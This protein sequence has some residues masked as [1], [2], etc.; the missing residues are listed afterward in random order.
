MNQNNGGKT[1]RDQRGDKTGATAHQVMFQNWNS[2]GKNIYK[3][4]ENFGAVLSWW[5]ASSMYN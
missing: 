4:G 2:Q 1:L 3:Y 5:R